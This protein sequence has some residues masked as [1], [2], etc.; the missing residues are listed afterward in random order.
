MDQDDPEKRIAELERRLAEPKRG[1]ELN[2]Q[3]FSDA[4]R[5]RGYHRDEVDAFVDRVEATLRDPTATG[6]VTPADVDE[7]AFSK[8]PIGKLGYSEAEVDAYLDRVKTE[9]SGRAPGRGPEEPI[10]CLLYRYASA[11]QQTPALA[12][13][14]GKDALRVIEMS[15]NALIASVS[16]AEVTVQPAQYGGIPVLIVDGPGL[17]T[18]TIIA[19]PPPGQWRSS[20]KSTKP[21]YSAVDADWLVLAEKFGLASDLV[22]ERGP[23]TFSEHVGR[24]TQERQ[25]RAP[26][27]WRTP[28]VLGVILVVPGVIY[29]LPVPLLIGVVCLI[30]A[31]VAWRLK[32]EF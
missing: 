10:R 25:M 26:T 22:D 20:P 14:V 21:A 3:A 2:R 8:P 24:F 30:V 16:L 1:P 27:S 15:G 17:P 7:V 18:L 28:L 29:W 13:E 12:I 9:L 19:H 4:S 11:D 32:W 6:G 31:A 23:Q 5:G